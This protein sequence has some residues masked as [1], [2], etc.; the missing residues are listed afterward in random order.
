LAVNPDGSADEFHH[1]HEP[2]VAMR[3]LFVLAFSL[4]L[5]IPAHAASHDLTFK[6]VANGDPVR[7]TLEGGGGTVNGKFIQAGPDSLRVLVRG[8]R[9]LAVPVSSVRTFSFADYTVPSTRKATMLGVGLGAVGGAVLGVVAGQGEGGGGGEG[10]GQGRGGDRAANRSASVAAAA[11]SPTATTASAEYRAVVGSVA[12][13]LVGG[14][15][16]SLFGLGL[17]EAHWTTITPA[18]GATSWTPAPAATPVFAVRIP[19]SF[20]GS[21]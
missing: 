13:A 20:P 11:T 21:R 4:T 5:T 12:G 10:G 1:R 7:L 8:G 18:A 15:L 3:S 19:W 6:G 16:G 14:V 17:T 9:T 2:E